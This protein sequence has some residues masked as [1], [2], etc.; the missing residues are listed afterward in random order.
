MHEAPSLSIKQSPG[1]WRSGYKNR[2]YSKFFSM[3]FSRLFIMLS[4]FQLCLLSFFASISLA[5]SIPTSH[6]LHEKRD[7]EPTQWLKRSRI[8]SHAAMPVRVA[9]TQSNLDKGE[10]FLMDVY[11]GT[12][13]CAIR[14]IQIEFLTSASQLQSGV[15]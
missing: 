7:F 2:P 4:V 5:A 14:V 8:P 13:D 3:S 15:T 6:V 12:L 1:E 11:V 9:L 10:Q